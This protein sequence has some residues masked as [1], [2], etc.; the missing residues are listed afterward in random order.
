MLVVCRRSNLLR[1]TIRPFTTNNP[2]T[3]HA[4]QNV[5]KQ[6][7]QSETIPPIPDIPNVTIWQGLRMIRLAIKSVGLTRFLMSLRPS[8]MSANQLQDALNRLKEGDAAK[9]EQQLDLLA[10]ELY[11]MKM[12]KDIQAA[13]LSEFR[14]NLEKRQAA[15]M[16]L[17][18]R[19]KF[20]VG[21]PKDDSTHPERFHV[22]PTFGALWKGAI[23]DRANELKKLPDMY[24]VKPATKHQKTQTT[25]ATTSCEGGSQPEIDNQKKPE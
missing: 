18:K 24:W 1:S 9:Q 10:Q 14:H 21:L 7:R 16:E 11:R 13:Q 12:V 23:T 22:N 17:A 20:V 25:T 4:R 5:E 15:E 8:K 6:E 2:S 19:T 3:P